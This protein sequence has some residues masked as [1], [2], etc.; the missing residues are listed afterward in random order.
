[1]QIGV[2]EGHAIWSAVYDETPN[3]LLD[4]ESRTVTPWLPPLRGQTF[5]DVACGTGR[6]TEL[7]AEQGAHVFGADFC[8]P[9]LA[10]AA[11]GAF[12]RSR[13]VQ[14]DAL[15]LSFTDGLAD[16]CVC[17]FA[18]GYMK[19]PGQLVAELAR[20]T[21]PGGHVLITDI[22]PTAIASGWRR[23]FRRAG[24]VYEIDNRAHS[25]AEYL[26]ASRGQGLTVE[27]FAEAS[28]GEP[29]RAIFRACGREQSFAGMC[30]I[31]AIFAVLWRRA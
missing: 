20:I 7:A 31:P 3:P 6:W 1:M 11:R 19:S 13:F 9:M 24:D 21:A 8:A 10:R 18:A 15:Q 2:Q 12:T 4:L 16:F 5:V 22:H 26:A 29:E 25:I 17:A 23:S 27:H 30:L 14:A 28:F